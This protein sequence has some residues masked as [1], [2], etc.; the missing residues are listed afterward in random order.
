[1][2]KS[3]ALLCAVLAVTAASSASTRIEHWEATSTTATSITGDVTFT[4]A[5]LTFSD[6]KSLAIRY[7]GIL[8]IGNANDPRASRA[9]VQLYRVLTRTQPA[10]LRG[11]RICGTT[12]S[13]L[14]IAHVRD[15]AIPA[16]MLVVVGFYDGA[17]PPR[18]NDQRLCA[19]Y[20]YAVK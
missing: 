11:N 20:L 19:T 18:R 2:G 16:M 15:A 14:T 7:A 5:R 13:F 9:P 10:L 8:H 3:L 12:P 4:P 17:S 6:G 1:M